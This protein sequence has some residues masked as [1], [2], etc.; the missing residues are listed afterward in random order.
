LLPG[1]HAILAGLLANQE[2]MVL[3]AHRRQGMVLERRFQE[4]PWTALLLRK[5]GACRA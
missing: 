3:A 2:R 5:P 4:G 1:G